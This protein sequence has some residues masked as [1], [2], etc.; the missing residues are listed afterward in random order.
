MPNLPELGFGGGAC[1]RHL[2]VEDSDKRH[3]CRRGW[4]DPWEQSHNIAH[5]AI[6]F[7]KMG[8]STATRRGTVIRREDLEKRGV[9]GQVVWKS[10]T[11]MK[12]LT[13]KEMKQQDGNESKRLPDLALPSS[14]IRSPTV[15]KLRRA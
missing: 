14:V 7:V 6:T 10:K 13:M 11:P 2:G 12:M 3:D 8:G 1:E 4:R 5:R 9:G 15:A